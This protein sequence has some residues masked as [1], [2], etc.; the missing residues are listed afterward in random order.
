MARLLFPGGFLVEEAPW[1]HAAAVAR[2]ASL[3][4][5]RSVPAIFEAAFEHSGIRARVDVLELPPATGGCARSRA[6][7]RSRREELEALGVESI[8]AIPDDFPLSARQKVVRD[9]T[10][11]GKLFVAPELTD[12]LKGYGPP[13]F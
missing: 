11:S 9:V 3:M 2:T 12:L 5:D 7:V 13:A 10:R 4:A 1:E 8:S 6:A